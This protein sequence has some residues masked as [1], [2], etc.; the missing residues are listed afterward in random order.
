MSDLSSTRH[1]R[2][3]NIR[4]FGLLLSISTMVC[5]LVV[6]S[7]LWFVIL[8]PG[9]SLRELA[10]WW[11]SMVGFAAAVAGMWMLVRAPICGFL[12]AMFILSGASQLYV[13][14]PLWY[15]ELF[16]PPRSAFETAMYAVLIL[17]AFIS[18][19][20]IVVYV[21]RQAVHRF[22][23]LFGALR[24]LLLVLLCA[25]FAYSILNFV[26]NGDIHRFPIQVSVGGLWI[27]A[28][29]LN[30]I[31]IGLSV[32]SRQFAF[33]A[34]A[35]RWMAS[36]IFLVAT[37]L[38]AIFAF[39]RVMHVEDELA[40]L[41]QAHTYA[42]GALYLPAL[43]EGAAEAFDHYL[44]DIKEDRWFSVFTP[45]WPIALALGVLIDAD[46][47]VNPVLGLLALFLGYRVLR[48]LSDEETARIGLVMMALSPW[49]ISM[50]SSFMSHTLALVL[51]LAAWELL[52]K[53]EKARHGNVIALSF[54][55]GA[56]MGWLFLTRNLDGLLMGTLTGVFMLARAGNLSSFSAIIS[57]SLGCIA[58]GGLIFPYNMY[59]TG[60]PLLTTLSDYYQR[61]WI[62]GSNAFGFG[63]GIGSPEGWGVLELWPHE[64][65]P[66]EGLINSLNNVSSLHT[67]FM[68]WG[69]GSLVLFWAFLLWG[70]LRSIDWC[71]LLV[72]GVIAL[73]HA[74]YW[75][76]ASYYIGARYWF[77]MFFP[78]IFLSARGYQ[79]VR[80]KVSSAFGERANFGVG[81]MLLTLC[82]FSVTVFLSY[83]GLT[84]YHDHRGYDGSYRNLALPDTGTG[85][86]PLVL[87]TPQRQ[88]ASALFFNDPWF[89]IDKPVYA[90]DLGADK[91]QALIDAFEG[92]PVLYFD[93]GSNAFR[94]DIQTK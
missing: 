93:E 9:A 73:V 84:R 94:R 44:L 54:L 47:L 62:D 64:H 35:Q 72:I 25:V 46:W 43:P 10:R 40:Y 33:G 18:V 90:R 30:L 17:Q 4:E 53:A 81:V 80:S 37:L 15:P 82:V 3:R 57:Y 69:L 89:P 68:G 79:T 38:L 20:A 74:F 71:M 2:F 61:N 45:G 76:A 42:K 1:G 21:D 12:S 65:S 27:V 55:A 41:Y 7:A 49:L 51:V 26:R 11:V 5:F 48:R 6:I 39:E 29:F 16:F 22:L 52:L 87:V 78:L 59:F 56:L 92:R 83:R 77:M 85:P 70:K 19:L 14:Q 36:G 86:A 63:S 58:I 28:G 67:D 34:A 50:S 88:I 31:A 91:N 8:G 13:T 75:F 66:L 23:S 60:D 24:L 32:P